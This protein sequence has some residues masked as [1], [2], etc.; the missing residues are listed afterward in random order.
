MADIGRAAALADAPDYRRLI[1]FL[2]AP[3]I[4]APSQLRLDVEQT[5]GG[6]RVTI[7]VAFT[8]AEIGR[9]FGRGGRNLQAIRAIVSAAAQLAGQQVS[10]EIQTPDSPAPGGRKPFLDRRPRRD[11]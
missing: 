6:R 9:I 10:L 5:L 3:L 11:S 8:D 4:D 7:R 1:A 2:F